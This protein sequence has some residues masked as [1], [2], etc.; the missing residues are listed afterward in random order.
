MTNHVDDVEAGENPHVNYE[1]SGRQGL[2]TAA[3]TGTPHTP[4]VS[5]HVVR[6]TI[7][8]ENNYGQAGERWR[9]ME[10]WERDDLVSNLVSALKRRD[11]DIQERMVGH[12]VQCDAG[13]GGRVAEGLGVAV[14]AALASAGGAAARDAASSA[15][16]SSG[17][18]GAG[19]IG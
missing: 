14:P 17:T 2:R 12:L 15:G 9:A 16:E 1:P 19:A 3:P 13:Y 18:G 4:F 7:S 8:R 11:R 5:G 10:S 6:R